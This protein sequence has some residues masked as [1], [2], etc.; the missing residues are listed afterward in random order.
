M[1]GALICAPTARADDESY[2]GGWKGF[3]CWLAPLGVEA[4][5]DAALEAKTVTKFF[6]PPILE[7]ATDKICPKAYEIV[8]QGFTGLFGLHT[9]SGRAVIQPLNLDHLGDGVFRPQA[10]VTVADSSG[11][12]LNCS[13]W[14]TLP[15]FEDLC[16]NGEL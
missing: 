6:I 13:K 4:L 10:A 14:G 12:S 2:D 8:A 7:K 3:V 16:A 1:A 9:H 11:Q 5:A 15:T